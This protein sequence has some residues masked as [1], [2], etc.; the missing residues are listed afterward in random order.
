MSI[1][2]T[3]APTVPLT[4]Y[5]TKRSSHLNSFKRPLKNRE[6]NPLFNIS[7]FENINCCFSAIVWHMLTRV[8]TEFEVNF[9]SLFFDSPL[10]A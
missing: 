2:V 8:A 4:S 3:R 6:S 9:P 1:H 10:I 7:R 5:D